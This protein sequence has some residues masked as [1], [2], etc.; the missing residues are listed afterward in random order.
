MS[1]SNVFNILMLL[2]ITMSLL[3]QFLLDLGSEIKDNVIFSFLY[4]MVMFICAF[5]C[6]MGLFHIILGK[7]LGRFLNFV[8]RKIESIV[9][10]VK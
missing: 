10:E 1:N 2:L 7:I 8:Q 9:I 3:H 5:C 4:L 6:L